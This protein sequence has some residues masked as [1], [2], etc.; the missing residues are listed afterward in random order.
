MNHI[1]FLHKADDAAVRCF[2]RDMPYGRTVGAAGKTAIS[3]Q[4]YIFAKAH[5]RNGRSWRKHFAHTGPTPG[6]FVTDDHAVA[7]L[8]LAVQNGGHG[9]F[10]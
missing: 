1:A 9:L 8:D 10:F 2:G 7:G 4:G 5:A 6:A 3:Q